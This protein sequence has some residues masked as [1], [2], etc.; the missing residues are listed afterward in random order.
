VIQR[1]RPPRDDADRNLFEQNRRV[2]E[3]AADKVNARQI[4][5]G[6]VFCGLALRAVRRDDSADT[7]ELRHVLEEMTKLRDRKDQVFARADVSLSGDRDSR[8]PLSGL[9][10]LIDEYGPLLSRA[11]EHVTALL[12]ARDAE[13]GRLRSY[14]NWARRSALALYAVGSLLAVVGTAL[15]K[16]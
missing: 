12:D 15:T 11:T 7:N 1:L 6:L 10:E 3:L 4:D 16:L 14:A 5:A 9:R 2:V 13:A 8:P